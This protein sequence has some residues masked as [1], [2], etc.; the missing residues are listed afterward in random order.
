MS[1]PNYTRFLSDCFFQDRERQPALREDDIYGVYVSWCLLNGQKPGPATSLWVAMDQRGYM[2][3][4]RETG[5]PEWPGL[6]LK[7]PAAVDYILTSQ[8]SL[9]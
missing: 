6:S 8:P 3:Q 5:R 2:N 4:H 9:L 7:G 1:V